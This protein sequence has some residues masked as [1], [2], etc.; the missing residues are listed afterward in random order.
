MK[1]TA[2]ALRRLV[3]ACLLATLAACAEYGTTMTGT[4]EKLR[5]GAVEDAI[6]SHEK[7]YDGATGRSRDLLYY[8][9]SGELQRA[10]DGGLD[11]STQS[12]LQA[13]ELVKGWE[14][15]ARGKLQKSVS[16]LGAWL[17]DDSLARYDGQDYEKVMLNTNLA[18][19]HLTK[20][21]W[22]SARVEIRKMYEREALIASLRE[23]QVD[24][25]AAREQESGVKANQ[26]QISD[27]KGYPVEI[28]DDPEVTR[29]R[30]S[31]QSA[32]SHYLA[33]FVFEALNEQS[34]A[35]AGYRQAIELRPD[36]PA[37][38][39]GLE[40]L[41]TV[42]P[43]GQTDVLVLLETGLVPVR[44]SMKVTLPVPLGSGVK[45]LTTAYPVIHPAPDNY[46][47]GNIELGGTLVPTA[48][49]TNLDA[50]ARRAL[51]DDMPLMI[52]RSMTRMA[53]S[54]AA[55]EALQHNSSS[56]LGSLM[57]LAVGIASAATASTDTREWRTL[58]GYISIARVTVKSGQQTLA[59]DTPH[60]RFSANVN[61]AGPRQV[62]LVRPLGT[63]LEVLASLPGDLPL[64]AAAAPA[65]LPK[66]KPKMAN[67]TQ[68][69][70]AQ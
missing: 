40:H 61:V 41:G 50:M 4:T 1:Q 10:R 3:S 48:V 58:P 45:L 28:F 27:I 59:F 33:G 9:E 52:T 53:V 67:F 60:G 35:A 7:T 55:Q 12:W 22:Q 20:G 62:I 23:K 25:L 2:S 66:G 49:V 47:P 6:A 42:P 19:N 51:K 16:T 21:D 14:D 13:D 30:N 64:Q 18:E 34:L 17:L 44:D 46:A 68:S 63:R 69:D 56:G 8:L 39:G 43:A 29:L 11:A 5:T 70:A 65:K 31:Y 37:L 32:A 57:S 54:G 24:A 26:T 38:R 15:E 36:V